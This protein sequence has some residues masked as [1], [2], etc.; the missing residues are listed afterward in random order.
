MAE[1][2][3]GEQI[4]RAFA[5]AWKHKASD[6]PYHLDKSGRNNEVIIITF[7][8]SGSIRDWYSGKAFGDTK[9]NL[10]LFPSLR[11]IGNDEA[12]FVNEEFQRRFDAILGLAKPSF[13]DE[14][15]KAIGKQKQIVFT[16]HS[17]GAPL[18]ILA[19][20]WTLDKYLTP[21]SHGGI[22][23]LCVTF[24][25]PLIG[26]HIL[27]HATRRENWSS[28]FLHFVMR[29]D[30]VPRIFFSP[31]SAFDQRF[32]A[33]SQFFN[34][35]KSTRSFTNESIGRDAAAISEFYFSVMSNTAAVTNHAACKQMGSI[36]ATLETIA[37]FIPLSPYRPFGTYIFCTGNGNERKKIVVRNP[38]AVLQLLFFFA[39]LST[40]EEVAQVAHRSLQEHVVNGTELQQALGTQNVVYLDQLLKVPPGT[41]PSG[42]NNLT[43]NDLDLSISARL[44]LQA[45]TLVEE[46]KRSN[47][48][49]MKKKI[50]SVDEKTKE[51]A[52]Y[53]E[54]WEHQKLGYY[55][56]FKVQEDPDE[57][58]QANVK[59]LELAAVWDEIIEL[60]R[61]YDLPDELEG[62]QEWIEIGTS[63]RRLVE[64]L[65]VS[66]YYRHLRHHEAG[67][68]MNKGRPRRYRYAQ[69]WLEHY[70]R[71]PEEAISESCFWAEV[72]DICYE[73]GNNKSS[74]EDVKERVVK[75]EGQIKSWVDN[76]ELG[77]DI[78]VKGSTLVKWWNALPSQHKQGSCIKDLIN[79]SGHY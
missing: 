40:E 10:K 79:A 3:S 74:F 48:V 7:P 52:K 77:K 28:Y 76:G 20:L 11:S 4:E 62:K 50:D 12:A 14:V 45:A 41:D 60:L 5:L 63:F 53:K 54:T 15:D 61:R 68:Y 56:A 65:D 13:A 51:L 35:A 38:D 72:E 23:P 26:N 42:R 29:Y 43:L 66:N 22:P 58:F 18:A 47:E 33:I 78:F 37:N 44:C 57:D 46:G 16:G 1:Q 25:S 75:L 64:P 31:L 17:S 2:R 19:T 71:K 73:T 69:R 30:V 67:P 59:R 21:K 8:A 34:P 55:D 27:S 24:G 70:K 49:R 9:V 39:Q 36:D 6:K 32:E